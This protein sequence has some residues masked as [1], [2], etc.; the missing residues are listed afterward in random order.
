[1]P[2]VMPAP[3]VAVKN[4]FRVIEAVRFSNW[5]ECKALIV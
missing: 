4:P 1:M 3:V 5:L 2:W